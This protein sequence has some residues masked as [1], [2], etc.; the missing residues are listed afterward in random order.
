MRDLRE[1][2]YCSWGARRV[3]RQSDLDFRKL[4]REGLT[5]DEIQL[6]APQKYSEEI[7]EAYGDRYK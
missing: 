5:L 4:L 1:L 3:C 6:K 2:G 7:T